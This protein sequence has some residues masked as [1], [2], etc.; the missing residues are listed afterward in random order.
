MSTIEQTMKS[1]RNDKPV[2][3][4]IFE[5][6]V[7]S[8]CGVDFPPLDVPESA[9]DETLAGAGINLPSFGQH[10][11][12]AHYTHLSDRNFSV[13]GNFYPLGSC[14]M[15][16]NP[17]INEWA[18]SQPGF[19][20]LHPLQDDDTI[21]GALRLLYETRAMLEEISGLH[22]VSL[23]PA[24]GAHGEFTAL[25]VIKAYYA[26]IGQPERQVVLAA[27]T[28]HGTNPASC[29]MCGA[30][31]ETVR[32]VDGQTDLEHLKEVIETVG[33]NKIACFMITNPSTAGLFDVHIKEIADII[34]DAGAKLYLDGANM[35][36][37]VGRVKP[38]DF[39]VDA[40]HYN[41][42]KTFSTPHGGGGPGAGPIGVTEELAPFLP[43]PQVM[44]AD[45][46]S[47]YLDRDRPKSIGKVRSFIGQ[48]GVLV[49]CWTYISACGPLGLRNV[50]ETAVLNANYIAARLQ[51]LYEM[52]YFSP[53]EGK[54]CAHE[55]VT[56]PRALL[57]KG[58]TL[59][60][61]AK[62][63]IDYNVHPP[64]MHWPVHDCL[65]VEPTETESK[66]ALDQF[67]DVMRTIAEEIEQDIEK[68]QCAPTEADIARADEVSA[69]RKPV[70]VFTESEAN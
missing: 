32:T 40:M 43:V 26:E 61:I 37:M 55:F 2:E 17:R 5:K 57:D 56:V 39:G 54:F 58:V 27:D 66:Y 48:F 12:M 53:E 6:H 31:V 29:T 46:G 63:M 70:I 11:V 9:I 13:D 24:A 52:P 28:A 19:A 45:D 62:R 65:M 8:M 60:D 23:Q 42:H 1:S 68:V 35:N 25:K 34:H 47:F 15:K 44:M 69:A 51:D 49:R 59:I 16:H 14:T 30:I 67:I 41:T 10:D 3:P 21:Q 18:A 33:A 4:L 50:A 38:S 7:E 64:T 36:A 20:C 22:E